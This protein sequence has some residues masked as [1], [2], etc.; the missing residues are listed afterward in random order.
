MKVDF[1]KNKIETK[2]FKG[3]CIKGFNKDH[4]TLRKGEMINLSEKEV[5]FW[6]KNG[7]IARPNGMFDPVVLKPDT[8]KIFEVTETFVAI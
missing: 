7:W 3:V 1:T 8:L 4:Y 5:D 6:K 2:S